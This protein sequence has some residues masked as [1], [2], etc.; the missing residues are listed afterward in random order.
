MRVPRLETDRLLIREFSLDDLDA[1]HQILDHDLADADTGTEGPATRDERRRWLE[2]TVLGYA[3]LARLRQPPY[4]D[5]A[6]VLRRAG[7]LIGAC[8]FVPSFAPFGLLA[9]LRAAGDP[10]DP[11]LFLPEVGLY[12]AIAPAHQGRGYATEAARALVAYAFTTLHLRR[13]VATTTHD[14]APSIAVM[15]KLAMRI[16]RN[17]PPTHP[18]S[19]SSAS[20]NSRF[21]YNPRHPRLREPT[22]R[23][24]VNPGP[25][26]S[27]P[28]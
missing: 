18:G 14:N 22:D 13:L 21:P 20:S 7:A 5:R 25:H 19:R 9:T 3:E 4:G 10:A 24:T 12:Y 6:I 15:R 26:R 2:W 28:C 8:G 1:V 23:R 16:D 27:L 17:P 11:S